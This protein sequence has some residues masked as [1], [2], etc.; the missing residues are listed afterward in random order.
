M[1][2]NHTTTFDSSVEQAP[3]IKSSISFPRFRRRSEKS[4]KSEPFRT[5]RTSLRKRIR[6][7]H[8]STD[9]PTVESQEDVRDEP[10][11]ATIRTS[12]LGSYEPMD[13]DS[14]EDSSQEEEIAR[15]TSEI[16]TRTSCGATSVLQHSFKLCG[17]VDDVDDEEYTPSELPEDPTVQE[18]FECVF[19]TQLEAGLP[20]DMLWEEEEQQQTSS[21]KNLMSPAAL[22]QSLS[23]SRLQLPI[24]VKPKK[25]F[26]TG[27]LVHIATYDPVSDSVAVS[28]PVH[29]SPKYSQCRCKLGLAAPGLDPKEWPQCPLLFRPTPGSGMHIKGVRFVNSTGYLWS[30]GDSHTWVESLHEHWGRQAPSNLDLGC[31]ECMVLPINNGNEKANES[32]VVDFVSPLFE[33]TILLRIRHAEGS[34]EKPYNDETGY[35]AGVNRRYQVVIRG[36]PLRAL[37]LT[38]LTT[39]FQLSRPCGKLPPKWILRGAL[40]LVSFFAPQMQADFDGPKPMSVSPLGSTPQ[41]LRVN[42]DTNIEPGQEEPMT[43]QESLLG[44]AS[45]D[46]STLT[47]ARCRK[48]AFDKLY[49]QQNKEPCLLPSNVYTFEFL[50]HLLNFSD[51]SIELGS[52]FGSISLVEMLDGQP[53]Q[54]MAQHG[55][56]KLW[57]FD[58]FH[59]S[60]H[61]D[62]VKHDSSLATTL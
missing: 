31:P 7:L 51:F 25:T 43:S 23:K 45:D 26:R 10:P 32:L 46:P 49:T 61:S 59:E 52:M 56:E 17:R 60:L 6:R 2:M 19:A 38:E 62:A 33:G 42:G 5:P 50:Q 53:L 20:H 48:K 9:A 35:F 11:C 14:S 8:T 21:R 22:H 18:S 34:T 54:V 16:V 40:K 57:G 29:Q 47:R 12:I 55:D 4:T 41:V 27:S 1:R 44:I 39:G 3:S 15:E 28:S 13:E 36:R 37:P 24:S 58:V 30:E